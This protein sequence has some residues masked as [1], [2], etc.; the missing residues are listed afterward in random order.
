MN[1][2]YRAFKTDNSLVQQWYAMLAH[3][4]VF[5]LKVVVVLFGI[6]VGQ[7]LLVRSKDIHT[8]KLRLLKRIEGV[9]IALQT[10]QNEW[11]IERYRRKGIRGDTK[12]RNPLF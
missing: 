9:R 1:S 3:L 6:L 2:I 8:K 10:P 4:K 7:A 12:W 11:W 5:G